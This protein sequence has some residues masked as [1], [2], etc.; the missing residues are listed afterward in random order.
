MCLYGLSCQVTMSSASDPID[1]SDSDEG[2]ID[3][4]SDE[5]VIELE[6]DDEPAMEVLPETDTEPEEDPDYVSVDVLSGVSGEGEIIALG[7]PVLMDDILDLGDV[8][9]PGVVV[10]GHPDGHL[11]IDIPPL[12]IEV[13]RV[14]VPA[15]GDKVP[16][17]HVDHVDDDIGVGEAFDIAILEVS[18]PVVS[19]MDIPSSDTTD[20]VSSSA[21]R[22]VGPSAHAT[23]CGTPAELIAPTTLEMGGPSRAILA[24]VDDERVSE[25]RREIP[26]VFEIGGP[27]RPATGSPFLERFRAG[28]FPMPPE[29]ETGGPSRP[30]PTMSPFDPYYRSPMFPP[31]L[32]ERIDSI[33]MLLHVFMH[34]IDRELDVIRQRR[35]NDAEQ[36]IILTSASA[37]HDVTFGMTDSNISEVQARV[38]TLAHGMRVIEE[39]LARVRAALETRPPHPPPQ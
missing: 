13:P 1:I 16:V 21:L 7:G 27:S 24:H 25:P 30:S 5:E 8:L 6:S 28:G 18:S 38:T 2:I 36:M 17:F 32:E 35:I 22:A 23:D 31:T 12:A 10:V 4:V 9:V 37:R 20:S 33:E 19:V 15:G 14:D 29:L 11:I 34:R 39:D 26:S 3:L